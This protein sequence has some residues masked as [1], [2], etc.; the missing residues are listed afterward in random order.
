MDDN[1]GW[2]LCVTMFVAVEAV[3][4]GEGAKDLAIVGQVSFEGIDACLGVGEVDQV[5][6]KDLMIALSVAKIP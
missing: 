5:D 3:V 2:R 1:V 6:I 4:G